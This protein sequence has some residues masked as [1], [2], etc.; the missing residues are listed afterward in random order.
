MEANTS[1]GQRQ[2]CPGPCPIVTN[3][4]PSCQCNVWKS[5]GEISP[6]NSMNACRPTPARTVK[7]SAT[8]HTKLVG[9]GWGL[10]GSPS[11]SSIPSATILASGS[12]VP[13]SLRSAIHYVGGAGCPVHLHDQRLST[14]FRTSFWLFQSNLSRPLGSALSV[15]VPLPNRHFQ[16]AWALRPSRSN[17]IAYEK[18]CLQARRGGQTR[19]DRVPSTATSGKPPAPGIRLLDYHVAHRRGCTDSTVYVFPGGVVGRPG[20]GAAPI[21]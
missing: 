8:L 18:G 19:T 20:C 21:I 6:R 16:C 1:T 3:R 5:G 15:L 17:W 2:P 14:T 11:H 10:G 7:M 13:S 4:V 12:A 9:L